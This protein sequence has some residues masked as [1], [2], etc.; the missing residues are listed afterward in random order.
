VSAREGATP[1][2]LYPGMT[3]STTGSEVEEGMC[4]L[5]NDFST[6][7]S[8]STPSPTEA[9]QAAEEEL[10]ASWDASHPTV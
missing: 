3:S 5:F 9:R 8:T 2:W 4:D 1:A 6:A 7:A 10:L